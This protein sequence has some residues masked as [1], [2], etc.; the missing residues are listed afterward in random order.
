MNM[1]SARRHARRYLL[2]P[3][4]IRTT[5]TAL[6]MTS[7]GR[8]WPWGLLGMQVVRHDIFRGKRFGNAIRTRTTQKPPTN[9]NSDRRS[10]LFAP[11]WADTM[12][13]RAH[14]H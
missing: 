10:G 8:F 12:V 11:A 6:P 2:S 4:T 13:W 14:R 9:L 5:W 1:P 7:A 3:V